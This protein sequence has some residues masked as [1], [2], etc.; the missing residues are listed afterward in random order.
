[1]TCYQLS[2]GCWRSTLP[3]LRVGDILGCIR[4]NTLRALV[5]GVTAGTVMGPGI[6]P[7]AEAS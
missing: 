3:G 6:D 1:M 7:E 2:C 5:I 4:C